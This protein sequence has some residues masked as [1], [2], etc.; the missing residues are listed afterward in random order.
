MGKRM[1]LCTIEA[2]AIKSSLG[3]V[4]TL[5]EPFRH[6]DVIRLL[7]RDGER[8]PVSGEQ[9]FIDSFGNF[10]NR[11]EAAQVALNNGQVNN[12]IA[13]PSLFSEDLW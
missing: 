12:L 9:G 2:V 4:Y 8:T 5:P 7:V 6:H 11:E 10:L 3:V 13:P 1:G